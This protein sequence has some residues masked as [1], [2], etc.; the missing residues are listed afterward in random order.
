MRRVFFFDWFLF[1]LFRPVKWGFWG[2]AISLGTYQWEDLALLLCIAS[3]VQIVAGIRIGQIEGRNPSLPY[4][5]IGKWIEAMR[6]LRMAGLSFLRPTR[7]KSK[8]IS[9]INKGHE[10]EDSIYIPEETEVKCHASVTAEWRIATVRDF[11]R[12]QKKQKRRRR[13]RLVTDVRIDYRLPKPQGCWI[14]EGELM[15]KYSQ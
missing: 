10:G 12:N 5:F 11:E 15:P 2:S 1:F 7:L 13:W 14:G 3:A 9:M 4:F 8:K 6:G